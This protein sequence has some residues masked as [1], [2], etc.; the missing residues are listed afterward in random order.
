MMSCSP[1]R[2]EH[3]QRVD[4][5]VRSR[6]VTGVTVVGVRGHLVAV[7][8]HVGRGLPSLTL[9][10]LPGATAS[11]VRRWVRDRESGATASTAGG[12]GRAPCRPGPCRRPPQIPP[13][14]GPVGRHWRRARAAWHRACIGCRRLRAGIA[15]AGSNATHRHST[16]TPCGIWARRRPGGSARVESRID[17]RSHLTFHGA[18]MSFDLFAQLFVDG[19]V[20]P[21]RV[22]EVLDVLRPFLT[23]G[24]EDEGL[25]SHP[26]AGWWRS[27]FLPRRWPQRV[28]G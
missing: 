24:T 10:G 26:F 20:A 1:F 11:D 4:G 13:G 27:R 21:V 28:H 17:E 7:E 15:C 12:R 14:R 16:H 2:S 19:Q 3:T 23:V 18:C 8:A 5:H 25:L 6:K 22:R 9:T